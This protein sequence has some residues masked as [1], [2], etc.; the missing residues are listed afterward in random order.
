MYYVVE[1][2]LDWACCK[3][4]YHNS[5]KHPHLGVDQCQKF[6]KVRAC[7]RSRGLVWQQEVRKVQII[8]A[9]T[10]EGW[11]QTT[12]SGRDLMYLEWMRELGG[13]E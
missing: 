1:R 10:R 3:I 11:L 8:Q 5:R 13:Y 2:Y 7:H 9:W 12:S 4:S 6:Y